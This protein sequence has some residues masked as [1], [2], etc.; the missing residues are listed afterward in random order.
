MKLDFEQLRRMS[1]KFHKDYTNDGDSSEQLDNGHM[2]YSIN[3]DPGCGGVRAHVQ[4]PYFRNLVANE[5][6][7]PATYSVLRDDDTREP[8]IHWSCSVLTVEINACMYKA[9]ILD[10][11][12]S[13]ELPEDYEIC[14]E[15]DIENLLIL[16]MN[17]TGWNM[18]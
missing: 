4:W 2:V 11:L 16:W 15:D 3:F 17:L 13:M 8:W 10:E 1:D 18:N 6:D 12:K 7:H 5:S 14:E 9:T